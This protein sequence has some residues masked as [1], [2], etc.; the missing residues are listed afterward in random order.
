M[1][2]VDDK[3]F[4]LIELLIAVCILGI[5]VVPLLNSFMSSFRMNSKGRQL[6][7]ATTLAQNEMEIFEKESVETLSTSDKYIKGPSNLTGYEVTSDATDGSYEFVRKGITNDNSGREQFDVYVTLDPMR[8]N[9]SEIYYT[10]NSLPVSEIS[11]IS[12][13][14]S[15]T[16][17]QTIKTL[18]NPVFDTDKDAYEWFYNNQHANIARYRVDY[19]ETKV[20]RVITLDIANYDN[21]GETCTSVKVTYEYTLND[22]NIMPSGRYTYRA[23]NK[24]I[25]DN[26]EQF[27]ADHNRVELKN[28]YLFYAPRLKAIEPDKDKI[29]VNNPDGLP[30]DVYIIRQELLI[31]GATNNE[32]IQVVPIIYKPTIEIFD[33][34]DGEYTLSRYHTNLNINGES[35]GGKI[36]LNFTNTA[37]ASSLLYSRND[38]IKKTNLRALNK[39]EAK[40]R[41]Y[42]MTVKVYE[43]GAVE[44]T[45]TPLVT[46][47]GTKID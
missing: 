15:A 28:V 22:P 5:I 21:S 13:I 16:Y 18:N 12:N 4:S 1:R 6:L 35:D 34:L 37:A 43:N 11:T 8:D 38:I 10:Q 20:D 9:S 23:V 32:Q 2:K 31:D 26:A 3:G 30:I 47:S 19:F 33:K 27:D 36:K 25:F 46:L 39:A 40:D 14:D 44:S 24:V 29:I 42:V 45:D 17:I 41:I 7:R